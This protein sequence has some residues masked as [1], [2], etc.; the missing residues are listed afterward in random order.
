MRYVVSSFNKRCT[1]AVEMAR[2]DGR[3]E[4][5]ISDSCAQDEIGQW[6]IGIYEFKKGILSRLYGVKKIGSR[7][8]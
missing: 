8:L 4:D 5:M 1:E 3:L 7:E 6:W 2:G